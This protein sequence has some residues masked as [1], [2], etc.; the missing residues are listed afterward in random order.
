M[1]PPPPNIASGGAAL[2]VP[3]QE[4]AGSLGAPSAEIEGVSATAVVDADA[5]EARVLPMASS[6]AA[7]IAVGRIVR[8]R[9]YIRSPS[10]LGALIR[11][12]PSVLGAVVGAFERDD[13]TEKMGMAYCEPLRM[14]V[15][16]K[17][18]KS[19]IGLRSFS[20]SRMRPML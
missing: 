4:P 2:R 10:P 19:E 18:D 5:A 17:N 15:N 11:M 1:A 9:V 3:L 16:T 13:R 12:S 14:I 20:P 7:A 6:S 8:D